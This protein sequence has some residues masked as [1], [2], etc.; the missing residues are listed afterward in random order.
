MIRFRHKFACNYCST[1][2][3]SSV[4][5]KLGMMASHMCN[6]FIYT[7]AKLCG[8]NPK[9]YFSEDDMLSYLQ[10][11]ELKGS[12]FLQMVLSWLNHNDQ[13]VLRRKENVDAFTFSF[14]SLGESLSEMPNCITIPCGGEWELNCG[15]KCVIST[16]SFD[17]SCF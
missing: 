14:P 12:L 10:Q 13:C 11:L 9:M 4:S 5:L 2:L 17:F 7:C 16:S 1:V 3:G 15:I 6:P 8:K